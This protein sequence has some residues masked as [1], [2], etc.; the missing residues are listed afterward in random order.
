M[1][2]SDLN[3]RMAIIFMDDDY[4]VVPTSPIRRLESRLDRIEK[5]TSSAEINR[6][7]EQIIE[8]IKSN[9][10]VIDDVVKSDAELRNEISKI[11]GKI[12]DLVSSMNEFLEL[13]RASATEEAVAGISQDVMQPLADKMGELVEYTKKSVETNQVLLSSLGTIENRLKRL[14]TQPSNKYSP[15]RR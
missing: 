7:I 12:D 8:L 9:Q 11:P 4:E 5:T 10:R 14:Y 3:I 13:L 15:F 6:L 1:T 2:G